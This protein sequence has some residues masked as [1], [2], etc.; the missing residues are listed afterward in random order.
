MKCRNKQCG[1]IVSAVANEGTL[2][3][4]HT[5]EKAEKEIEK[6]KRRIIR[7]DTQRYKKGYRFTKWCSMESL[8]HA[9]DNFQGIDIQLKKKKINGYLHYALY[10]NA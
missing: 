9:Y 1:T 4:K 5:R 2:C 3:F 7:E 6:E 8:K 10:R